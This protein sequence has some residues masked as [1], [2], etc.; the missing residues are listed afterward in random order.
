VLGL[1]T[2]EL[3]GDLFARDD[4][5]AQVNVTERSGTDLAA[6]TVLVTDSEILCRIEYQPRDLLGFECLKQNAASPRETPQTTPAIPFFFFGSLHPVGWG[7]SRTIVVILS[8]VDKELPSY[9]E[10]GSYLF[11]MVNESK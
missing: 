1:D 5:G 6:D 7:E 3:D 4:V 10:E 2:L 8:D 9:D 11:V